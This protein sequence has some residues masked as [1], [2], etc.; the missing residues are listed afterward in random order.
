MNKRH[1]LFVFLSFFWP[2]FAFTQQTFSSGITMPDLQV[3]NWQMEQGLPVNS[4]MSVTQTRDGWMY[5]ATEEG[6]VRFDGTAFFLM[7]KSMIPGMTVNFVT[8]IL[9]SR[10]SSLWIGTE[11]G[12]LIQQKKNVYIKFDTSKGLSDNRI[13][14]LYEDTGG[15]L[16]VGTSGGGLNYIKNGKISRFDTSSGLASNYVRSV[17]VD[18]SGRIWVGTQKGLSVITDGKIR[19]YYRKDGLPDDFIEALAID[20][21]QILWIGTKSGGLVKLK[22]GQFTVYST[23]NGLSDKAVTSLCFDRNDMLWIGTNGGGI[24]RMEHE[25]FI[26]FTTKDGLSSNLIVTLFE[27]LEGNIWAGSSGS[28]IDLIKRKSVATLTT[29]D[30][31]PGDVIL[32]VLEDHAGTLWFSVA[33]K[34][35][36]KLENGKIESLTKK[37]GLATDLILALYEDLD[38]A[39]WIGTAGDGL[40]RFKDGKFINFTI[41]DGLSSNVVVSLYC[42]KAG[43]IWAGTT[44]SGINRFK[45][46]K[47]EIITARNGLSNDNINCILEDRHANIWVGT[48]GGLNKINGKKIT[49]INQKSG[50]SNDY[51][52]S[53]LEDGDGNF[54]VGTASNGLNLIKDGK[55]TQFT[56]KDG[57]INEVVLRILED[58]FGNL[59]ISCNKGIYKIKKRDLL[60]FADSKIKSLYPVTYGKTDGMESIE[61]NGGVTPAG[62]KTHDGKLLFPTMKGIAIIDP[63]MVNSEST[64]FSPVFIEELLVDGQSVP[65]T[66]KQSIP[67]YSKRLEFRYAAL[68]YSNPGRIR[69]RC[70]LAGFDKDWVDCG[71]SK[72]AYY[73][74]IPGGHYTF[75]VMATNENGEW[76]D[77]QSA[78][79][80]FQLTPPFYR[81]FTFYLLISL[82]FVLLLFFVTYYFMERFQRK[83]LKILVDQRTNELHLKMVAQEQTQAELQSINS[84]LRFAKEQA[85]SSDRLKTAFMNNISHEIRTPLNGILGFGQLMTDSG[86]S[87]AERKNY[88]SILKSSSNRLI[89]TVTDFMDVSLI[90]SGN[91][92]IRNGLFPLNEMMVELYHKNLPACQAVNLSLTVQLPSSAGDVN[93]SSDRELLSK[94]LSH[95]L[96]NAIK[97]T[98]KGSVI[99]GFDIREK[100][101]EFFVKDTGVGIDRE[102]QATIFKKF[103]QVDVSIS[104]GYDGSGLGLSIAK[105]FVELL[106]G[107]IWVESHPGEG[108]LFRFTLPNPLIG[109][110]C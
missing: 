76:N 21:Q 88:F 25:R 81:S 75:R 92:E 54:W 11:G 86:L 52:L 51:I 72:A 5:L 47:F 79:L 18:A 44:G 62:C 64:S 96:N 68:N 36:N 29:R 69:Y 38:H 110:I 45:N 87:E 74:N 65:I 91:Q 17:L 101:L 49:I 78:E 1:L 24:T 63:K 82:F 20:R 46:G 80:T 107:R 58:D 15:G 31:L 37:Y 102:G 89:N 40:F 83:R 13:F 100:E 22:D 93:I 98:K 99:F 8:A 32:P 109:R 97:F 103:T 53:L 16:W 42:D 14:N 94:V 71:S 34:G 2:G 57:L 10:D 55:I 23:K 66:G 67:S 84:E 50:L 26:P 4:I 56:T 59:W 108:S 27:D 28:G 19:S 12:G 90:T 105:G 35:L 104:R 48:N 41:A 106:G 30:G 43:A 9:G 77:Q 7:N 39:I 95:L 6:L 73:T 3:E 70:M 61:C 33:G 60:D 85:E